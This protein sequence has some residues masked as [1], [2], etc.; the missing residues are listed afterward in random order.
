L[1][2][3]VGLIKGVEFDPESGRETQLHVRAYNVAMS[4]G[5]V[6]HGILLSHDECVVQ[7]NAALD[8]NANGRRF[9]GEAGNC[10]TGSEK[11]T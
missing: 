1:A 9:F 11:Q 6:I 7:G 5:Y 4:V 2:V 8:P 3:L 10:E